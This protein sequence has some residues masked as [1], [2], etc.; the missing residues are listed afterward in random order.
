MEN[1]NTVKVKIENHNPSTPS[2]PSDTLYIRK[3]VSS[4]T[5]KPYYGAYYNNIFYF[6][7]IK[8]GTELERHET[9]KDKKEFFIW[10]GVF[11]KV[12]TEDKHDIYIGWKQK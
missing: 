2:T 7:H 1:N 3:Y 12:D 11:D 9:K 8:D 5:G 10:E 6:V 4:R